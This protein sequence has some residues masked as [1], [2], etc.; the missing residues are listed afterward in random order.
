MST[1]ILA[2]PFTAGGV[3][4]PEFG[5]VSSERF[6]VSRAALRSNICCVTGKPIEGIGWDS[7]G[8][9]PSSRV[10]VSVLYIHIYIRTA[11]TSVSILARFRSGLPDFVPGT[12]PRVYPT[13]YV[14]R[15]EP[16]CLQYARRDTAAR[17][18]S[19]DGR[20]WLVARHIIE[21]LS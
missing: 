18:T 3:A 9:E 12:V 13:H 6:S 17:P 2:L 10:L 7:R 4:L 11:V 20:Q 1:A 5:L 16:F 21:M 15:L 8:N 19:A 14:N